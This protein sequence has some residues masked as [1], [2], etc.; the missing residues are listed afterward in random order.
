MIITVIFVRISGLALHVCDG[1]AGCYEE[2]TEERSTPQR[3]VPQHAFA[4]GGLAMMTT[5]MM[6]MAMTMVQW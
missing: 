5:T 6:M 3:T 2:E 1:C 4:Y